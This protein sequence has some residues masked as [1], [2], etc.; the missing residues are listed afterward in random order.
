MIARKRIG[1]RR[2]RIAIRAA[3][4]NHSSIPLRLVRQ[5]GAGFAAGRKFK[6]PWRLD[7]RAQNTRGAVAGSIFA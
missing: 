6:V 4:T 7:M 5:T 3:E 1:V 2:A